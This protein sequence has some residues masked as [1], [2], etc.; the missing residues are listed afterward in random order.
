MPNNPRWFSPPAYGMAAYSD[1]FTARQ[2]ASLTTFSDL[3]KEA[4][5]RVSKDSG[6]SE[7]ADGIATYLAFAISKLADRGSSICSWVIQ[8]ESNRN[9]FARQA[10]P[11]T[12]DFIEMNPLLRG[13]GSFAGAA[14]WTIESLEG[15]AVTGSA[16]VLQRDAIAPIQG[17]P[18]VSTDPPYYDNI[19]YADLS[20]FFYV[21]L[22]RSLR[23]YYPDLLAT[24]LT[25]KTN[26]LIA[27]PYRFS[28]S[29]DKAEKFFK[30]G[31]L[32][33]FTQIRERQPADFPTTVI[34]AF[35]QSE[36][37]LEGEAST[38]W[39]KMLTGL[40]DALATR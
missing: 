5:S 17:Q 39:E 31:F 2:L 28:G 19:G 7:Y 35:K 23:D 38:G 40:L 11:M 6:S 36:M 34:Y 8:R 12:W 16:V 26:E 3:I 4:H 13:T 21:W 14:A 9:T 10:I 22:R 27:T 20:D 30:A 37:T 1:L 25:P 15:T 18:V 29:K 32:D 24:V 33:V